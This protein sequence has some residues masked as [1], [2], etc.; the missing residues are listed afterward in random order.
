MNDSWWDRPVTWKGLVI[1]ML[2][3]APFIG[4]GR[5]LAHAWLT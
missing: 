4:F 1:Y 3:T 2:V 5:A